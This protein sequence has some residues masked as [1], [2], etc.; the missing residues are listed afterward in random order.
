MKK[1]KILSLF[2]IFLVLLL[3]TAC[4]SQKEAGEEEK[5]EKKTEQTNEEV[6]VTST[7]DLLNKDE[8]L[9]CLSQTIDEEVEVNT[10]YYFDNE[11]QRMRSD[12]EIY[13]KEE[14]LNY[15]SSFILK[16]N[17][18]YMWNDL[19]IM[20]GMKFYFDDE[21]E[22]DSE[23]LDLQEELEFSCQTWEVDDSIFDLPS[24]VN[25]SDMTDF[26]N[27]FKDINLSEFE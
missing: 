8:S 14:D 26:L 17:W 23:T 7:K 10:T 25:F 3:L 9:Y 16:D 18:A 4:S 1:I 24:E 21:E 19:M 27:Q 13:D 12:S 2:S 20:D 6:L 11:K 22:A 5:E 15:N